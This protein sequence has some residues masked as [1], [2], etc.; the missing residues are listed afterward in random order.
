MPYNCSVYNCNS[1]T[2]TIQYK[3][4]SFPREAKEKRSW[5]NAIKSGKQPSKHAKV[6]EKHFRNDDYVVTSLGQWKILKK[7]AIPSQNLPRS[8]HHLEKRDSTARSERYLSRHTQ[9]I[10]TDNDKHNVNRDNEIVDIIAEDVE[11]QVEVERSGTHHA[12][13]QTIISLKRSQL[14]SASFIDEAQMKH[15][16]GFSRKLFIF[17]CQYFGNSYTK[18]HSLFTNE[19]ELLITLMKYR[20]N[21][22]Y[23]TLAALFDTDIRIIKSIVE[24][25]TKHLYTN[26]RQINFWDLKTCKHGQY[27]IVLDCTEFRI[28]RSGDPL[29]QQ[30]T[31]SSY[32]GTNTFKVLIGGTENGEIAFVS[33]VYGGS[34]TDRKISH[35]SGIL[36]L[37]K[38]ADYVLANRGFDISD[39][40]EEKHVHLNIPPF[41]KGA[42]LTEEEIFKTRAIAN[43]RIIIENLIGAGKKNK[44]LSDRIPRH[45]WHIT[46]EIV[47]NCMMFINFKPSIVHDTLITGSKQ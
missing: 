32:Y 37:L 35:I 2:K 43:R 26:F 22:H 20:L 10:V 25:W 11:E 16:T 42:Q 33:D 29:I 5:L 44:I 34:I 13:I 14:I 9:K 8:S 18:T 46:N 23:T 4:H 38:E 1:T 36:D 30:A 41:K 17:F 3:F 47:Y 6:C 31:Y 19:D 45:L 27:T 12:Q 7:S 40:L 21:L 28:E 15:M 39:L 24:K